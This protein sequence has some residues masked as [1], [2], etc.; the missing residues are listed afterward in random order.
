MAPGG[1]FSTAGA[2]AFTDKKD[3]S[4][5]A[6]EHVLFMARLEV[7]KGTD[8]KFMPKAVTTAQKASGYATTTREQAIAMGVR[9]YE[10]M[11]AIKSGKGTATPASQ[12]SSATP[13]AS[14]GS[15]AAAPAATPSN[16][17]APAGNK[18]ATPAPGT[19]TASTGDNWLVGTWG[20]SDSNT[21]AS[22]DVEFMIEFKADG[23]FHKVAS[24]RTSWSRN[25]T[26]YNGKYRT[27]GNKLILYNQL[28]STGP[29]TGKFD[30]IWIVTMDSYDTKDVPAE[31]AEYEIVKTA[32]GNLKIGET[33]YKRG[34]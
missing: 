33:E 16:S 9:S 5:W 4:S 27:E 8:G 13:A 12:S 30:K 31:D 29:A 28:K 1:D 32:D 7:I 11:D 25:G 3:I 17:P 6:L 20:Y 26:E 15:K 14:E 34:R 18:T 2:P 24:A 22:I 23:T 19:P 21:N 10:Q